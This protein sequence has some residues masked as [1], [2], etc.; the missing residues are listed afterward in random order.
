MLNAGLAHATV[1]GQG[2]SVT[3]RGLRVVAKH[4]LSL[5][6]ANFLCTVTSRRVLATPEGRLF[7]RALKASHTTP[8]LPMANML[9]RGIDTTAPPGTQ[10]PPARTRAIAR[11][12]PT[13]ASIA[14]TQK[15]MGRTYKNL[16][17]ANNRTQR[18]AKGQLTPNTIPPC[19]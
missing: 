18:T 8:M 14:V 19:S 15:Q 2:V 5:P 7:P 9:R 12:V 1:L 6:N 17:E 3:Q 13:R 11:L 10:A 16:P 4:K